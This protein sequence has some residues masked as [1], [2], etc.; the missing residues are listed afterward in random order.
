MVRAVRRFWGF[1]P[2]RRYV[3]LNVFRQG[4]GGLE[5][6]NSTLLT[7]NAARV[8]T[9]EG[10]RS[11]LAFAGHEYFHAFNVKRLRPA[12]LGPFDYEKEPRT[13]SLWLSEGVTSYY[14]A[15]MLSRAGLTAPPDFLASMSS[16]IRQLQQAPGRLVQTLEQSSYD[17]WNN[18]LS[19]VNPNATTVSY[20]VKG[21]VVGL[22]LD[23]HIRQMTGGSR[24]LDD[25]MRLAYERYAGDR[26]FTP[27]EFRATAEEVARI[28]LRDWFRRALASTEELDYA[29]ALSWYGLRFAASSA[30]DPKAAWTLEARDDASDAQKTQLRALLGGD[31]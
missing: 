6:K 14:A 5:H 26:G 11:W 23:A 21:E 3:F 19:G 12:E 27:D 30:Q 22:L 8:A 13:T 29:E 24:S 15:L 25:V 16:V 28:D 9:P 18:S 10:Y 20:Y 17:V 31:S 7:V 1:L 4:G 2:Y